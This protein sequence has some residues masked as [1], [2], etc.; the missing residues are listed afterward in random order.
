MAKTPAAKTTLT[1]EQTK[2]QLQDD[3]VK[4]VTESLSNDPPISKEGQS[5]IKKEFEEAKKNVKTGTTSKS[6]NVFCQEC[7]A[8]IPTSCFHCSGKIP[9]KKARELHDQLAH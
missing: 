8:E 2:K 6:T 5:Q 3:I 1:K 9:E 7:G 4:N